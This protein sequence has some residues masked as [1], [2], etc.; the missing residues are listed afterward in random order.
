MRRTLFTCVNVFDR[1]LFLPF[2]TPLAIHST[3]T[4]A[5]LP[6]PWVEE[7]LQPGDHHRQEGLGAQLRAPCLGLAASSP[8]LVLPRASGLGLPEEHGSA[9]V[10]S[11]SRGL[12][13]GGGGHHTH[14]PL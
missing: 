11:R 5:P 8:T 10:D 12:G 13:Q 9:A 6:S 4:V 1:G 14:V 7:G 2:S 3:G